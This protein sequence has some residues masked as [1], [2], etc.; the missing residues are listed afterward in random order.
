MM[1]L[2]LFMKF[3][4]AGKTMTNYLQ[5]AADDLFATLGASV[6]YVLIGNW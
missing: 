5:G 1:A 6:A 3:T 4:E 2:N